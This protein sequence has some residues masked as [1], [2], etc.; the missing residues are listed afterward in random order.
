MGA[1]STHR[2]VRSRFFLLV[3]V[4][5]PSLLVV[6]LSV[7]LQ[8]TQA[9][10]I[11][12]VQTAQDVAALAELRYNEW[13]LPDQ[14]RQQHQSS[15]PYCSRAAFGAA[16]A[17]IIQERTP[18]ATPFLARKDKQ[19]VGSAELSSVELEGVLVRS[20]TMLV[21]SSGR[22]DTTNSST[23]ITSTNTILYVTDVVTSQ[24]HRR[25]GIA[26]ALMVALE[27]EARER[28]TQCLLLHVKPDN[29]GALLFYQSKLGYQETSSSTSTS[30]STSSST[31][32][33][34]STLLEQ[35][36][37]DLNLERLTENTATQGQ[38]L[39]F[40][41]LSSLSSSSCTATTPTTSRKK[42]PASSGAGFGGGGGT[43]QKK[44]AK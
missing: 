10:T 39:L 11:Q 26:Q 13:I 4:A 31:D 43:K 37:L 23:S 25:Q 15:S 28:G 27:E 14:Q 5:L 9:L 40:K 6:Q 16:T 19:P 20:R 30:I 38:I 32:K 21:S 2:A 1:R 34:N 35:L 44:R 18:G 42:N 12:P 7:L 3:V 41:E 22:G 36:G 8:T 17:E 29:H 33:N 24:A